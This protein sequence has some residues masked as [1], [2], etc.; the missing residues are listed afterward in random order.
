MF[1]GGFRSVLVL[2]GLFG[3]SGGGGGSGGSSPERRRT[4][5]KEIERERGSP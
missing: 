1:G 4:R 2:E 3:N 5:F